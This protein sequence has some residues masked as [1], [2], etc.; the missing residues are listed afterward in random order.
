LADLP[1]CR[2]ADLLTGHDF[3][4]SHMRAV[5]DPVLRC[6]WSAYAR[7]PET[8]RAEMTAPLLN[9]VRALLLRPF[10][11]AVLTAART[12]RPHT[13]AVEQVG[14]R[15]DMPGVLDGGILLARIPK[16][17]LG[18]EG[19]R[20]VRGEHRRARLGRDASLINASNKIFF[21]LLWVRWDSAGSYVEADPRRR[22]RRS[23]V[24]SPSRSD[25]G[26]ANLPVGGHRIS[27]S[28]DS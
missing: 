12:D 16:G 19:T 24:R 7:L 14:S 11:R 22:R 17:S 6:F 15:V 2:P 28:A 1:T 21:I 27:S 4:A 25:S 8:R 10:T 9:K 13:R 20:L 18:D 23:A 3:R 5:N 26:H